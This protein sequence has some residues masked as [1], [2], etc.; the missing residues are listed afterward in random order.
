MIWETFFPLLFFVKIKSLSPI[1]GALSTLL[2]NKVGLGPLNPVIPEKEKYLSSQQES[3][4][5][6]MD[7][8]GGGS[9]S[10]SRH[11][12]AIKED[13]IDGQK[14]RDD[15]NYATLKVLVGYIIGTDRRLL[16]CAKNTGS[17][18]NV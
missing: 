15:T 7:L 11:L 2:V 4:E 10:N 9:F 16:L 8:T 17:W 6:I 12:L 18:M 3:V 13:R 1:V 14:N 5:L